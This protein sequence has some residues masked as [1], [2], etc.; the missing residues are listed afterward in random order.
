M[1]SGRICKVDDQGI[2]WALVASFECNRY[3]VAAMC[4]CMVLRKK[5]LAGGVSNR[6]TQRQIEK[7]V[8]RNPGS[9]Q[10]P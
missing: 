1:I 6:A 2:W 10:R 7:K 8:C 5:N 4:C 3:V 9:N